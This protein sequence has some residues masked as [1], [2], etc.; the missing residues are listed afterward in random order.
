MGMTLEKIFPRIIGL[1]TYIRGLQKRVVDKIPEG[2]KKFILMERGMLCLNFRSSTENIMK[3][4]VVPAKFRKQILSLG[5]DIPMAGHLGLKKTR[6][7]IMRH[8]FCQGI[9]DDTKK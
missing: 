9:L 6:D 4:L 7:R 8:F 1:L 3:Q 2:E 5:H